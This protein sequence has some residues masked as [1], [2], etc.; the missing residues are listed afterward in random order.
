[1]NV[2]GTQSVC[3]AALAAGCQRMVHV[4]TCAVY[5]RVGDA[6]LD[7]DSPHKTAGDDY[8][9]TKAGA[10]RALAPF[11]RD[12]LRVSIIRPTAI[13]GVHPSSSW[14]VKV[15]AR[16]RD[17]TFPIRIDGSD[18][19]GFVNVESVVD[20]ILLVA[21]H[22]GAVG[23]AFN[24]V[25]GMTTWRNYAEEVRGWFPGCPQLPLVPRDQLPPGGLWKGKFA[26]ERIRTELGHA[27]RR[28]YADGMAEAK[29]HWQVRG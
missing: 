17:G 3:A 29:A 23:R 27:P 16:I 5:E 9:V 8:S 21:E 28:T 14:S 13:F 4:S 12:G 20:A 18:S 15:P 22:P 7:E 2:V 19:M 11:M 24:A 25:D 1:M 26:N 10:E 6:Q